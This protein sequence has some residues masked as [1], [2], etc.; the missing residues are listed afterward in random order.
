MVPNTTRTGN[1]HPANTQSRGINAKLTQQSTRNYL[2]ENTLTYQFNKNK[3][4][5]NALAGLTF[6]KYS[7]YTTSITQEYI[8]NESFGMAGIGKSDATP[9]TTASLGDNAMMSYFTRFNYNYKSKYYANFTVRADGSSKFAKDN[10]WG[11]FPSGSLAW[12]F[13]RE[14][15][16]SNA[17][18]WLSNGKL[19]ASWGLTGNNRIG[20]YD[21]MAQLITHSNYYKYPWRNE[22]L[23]RHCIDEHG[24]PGGIRTVVDILDEIGQGLSC[25]GRYWLC[26]FGYQ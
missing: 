7:D 4:S 16:V 14:S 24:V 20:N 18:P 17:L 26:G 10:R 23:R 13:S 25:S 2:N 8:T 1:S 12:T 9:T 19:R 15:F 11:Y 3:H 22:K 5:F 6:Q 21:Y